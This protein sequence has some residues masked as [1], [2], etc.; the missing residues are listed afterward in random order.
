MFV[1]EER[2]VEKTLEVKKKKKKDSFIV[3]DN[4]SISNDSVTMYHQVLSKDIRIDVRKIT[5]RVRLR[6]EIKLNSRTMSYSW[7]HYY[8]AKRGI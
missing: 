6:L 3:S 1:S 8:V 7:N 5:P 2:Y 4:S